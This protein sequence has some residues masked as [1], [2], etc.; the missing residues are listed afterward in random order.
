MVSREMGPNAEDGFQQ[1]GTFI[2][3]KTKN[4]W[5]DEDIES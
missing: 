1:K 5:T 4:S 2:P 3:Q